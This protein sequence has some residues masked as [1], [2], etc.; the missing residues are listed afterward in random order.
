MILEITFT[1][2]AI[3]PKNQM[4]FQN[5]IKAIYN[6]HCANDCNCKR[7]FLNKFKDDGFYLIDA[8]EYL[9]TAYTDSER[10]RIILDNFPKLIKKLVD[11]NK[12]IL[13]DNNTK[14][15]LIKKLVCKLLKKPIGDNDDI[16]FDRSKGV[17]EVGFPIFFSDPLFIS[18]LRDFIK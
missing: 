14:I 8:F 15:I 3:E 6:E 12:R 4:F 13:M 17:G 9:I 7:Y 10:E 18:N 1:M 16:I 11:F 5:V 2:V